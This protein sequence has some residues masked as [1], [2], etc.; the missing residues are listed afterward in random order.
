MTLTAKDVAEIMRL[1]E[2][3]S[4]DELH[5][6]TD[7]LKLTVR[8]H[9]AAPLPSGGSTADLASGSHG[10]AAAP[11]PAGE[12]GGA[13]PSNGELPARGNGSADEPLANR[14]TVTAPMLGTFYRAPKPGAPPFVEV[15]A[16]VVEDTI[17]GII[18]VMKLMNTVRAGAR[19]RVLEI[20]APDGGLVEYGQPLLRIETQA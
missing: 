20:P 2:E 15:G 10:A 13:Q 14:H 18:E 11:R 3:S 8:R 6:E 7:G 16:D 1:L 17:I 12:Q 5:L 19:G 4:F 9:G